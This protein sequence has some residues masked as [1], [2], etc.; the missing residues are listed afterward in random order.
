[1]LVEGLVVV[2]VRDEDEVVVVVKGLMDVLV[3]EVE[4][5]E[6]D[7]VVVDV[8][9][10]VFWESCD[11]VVVEELEVV[12]VVVEDPDVWL[13][14]DVDC[15]VVV[16]VV[17]VVVVVVC[18]WLCVLDVKGTVISTLHLVGLGRNPA[19]VEGVIVL[20]SVVSR[21][22]YVGAELTVTISPIPNGS[23]TVLCLKYWP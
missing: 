19:G 2:V 3:V 13:S 9:V 5:V 23:M 8:V 6:T 21:Q 18:S 7:G 16:A 12:D 10:G 4:V 22:K 1:M 17:V 20:V 15:E 11:V 14:V